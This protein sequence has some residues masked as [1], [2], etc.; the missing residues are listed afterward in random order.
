MLRAVAMIGV[1]DVML[2]RQAL[3]LALGAGLVSATLGASITARA[4][5]YSTSVSGTQIA[6]SLQQTLSGT[7]VHLH[8]LG[9]LINGSYNAANQ[10]ISQS[11]A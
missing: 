6:T 8:T 3:R 7:T 1:V 4:D 2:R 11:A 10:S 5:L 9:P